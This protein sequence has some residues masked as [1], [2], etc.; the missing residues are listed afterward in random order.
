MK[1]GV[2]T[3][4]CTAMA[5][6][7]GLALFL[8]AG[9][10]PAGASA[11]PITISVLSGRADLVSGGDALVRI[12]GVSSTNGLKVTVGGTNRTK[13]FA[14]RADGAVVGLVRG[15]KLGRSAIIAR[16]GTRAAQLM[17]TN[18][19]KSGP[20][21]SGPQLQPW[22][23]QASAKD[24]QCN[25]PAKFT[26]VYK[27]TDPSKSG[28][29]PYDPAN[30]PSDVATTKTQNGQTLPFIVRQER[31]FQDR[32]EYKILTL[33]QPGQPWEPWAPTPVAP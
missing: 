26:Y 16:A 7:A 1:S 11:G 31:G 24:A 9:A 2:R 19:P 14:K 30:P 3:T 29:Q 13:A 28:F 12:G 5:I 22:K 17:V 18:H 4:R 15:L 23:C 27:S 6:G 21:F 20:I 8:F 33:F 25:E 10:A 32:D